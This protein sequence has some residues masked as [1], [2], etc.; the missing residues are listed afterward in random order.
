MVLTDPSMW[1][2]G[3]DGGSLMEWPDYLIVFGVWGCVCLGALAP[4]IGAKGL[5]TGGQVREGGLTIIV[6][7]SFLLLLLISYKLL[8]T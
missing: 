6:C 2:N 1:R 3:T 8:L 4:Q 7:L 5:S